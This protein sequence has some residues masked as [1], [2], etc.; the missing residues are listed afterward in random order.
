MASTAGGMDIEATAATTPEKIAR[1]SID[2]LLGIQGYHCRRLAFSLGLGAEER[3]QFMPLLAALYRLFVEYDCSLLEINP[4]ILTA[5]QKLMVLDAKLEVDNNA[6]FRQ[7][8]VR[9]FRDLAEEEPLEVEA[10]AYHLSYIKL[11]GTIGNLV[12]GAGLAMATMDLIKK[13]GAE[14]AN[15]LDVGGGATAEMVENGFRI[16]LSDPKVKAILVNIFGG[17]L[18]GDILARGIVEAARTCRIGVPVIVRLEGTNSEAG[19][20]ILLH[21]GLNFIPAA[22]LQDAARQVA[23]AAQEK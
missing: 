9:S 3:Q 10:Q 19:R 23:M 22:D 2:P 20:Q 1:I 18:R 15:F 16:I 5:A 6:L 7:P 14:P 21:S 11:D 17:I 8:L 4:L 13:A 12:N